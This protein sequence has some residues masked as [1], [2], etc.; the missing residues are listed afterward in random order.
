[1]GGKPPGAY[2][3][4]RSPQRVTRTTVQLYSYHELTPGSTYL[5]AVVLPS[6]GVGK[7][8]SPSGCYNRIM[9]VVL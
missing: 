4:A 5:R 8:S 6:F 9:E 3:P 1:M 7:T 2:N